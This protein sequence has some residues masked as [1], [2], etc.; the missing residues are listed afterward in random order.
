MLSANVTQQANPPLTGE[1]VGDT[2]GFRN[3]GWLGGG[4]LV[5]AVLLVAVSQPALPENG[6]LAHALDAVG[7]GLFLLY[8]GVRVWATLFIG[9]HKNSVLQTEGPYS[10]CRN[11]LY[12]GSFCFGLSVGCFLKSVTFAGVVLLVFVAYSHWVVRAEEKVLQFR[13]G[14]NY[15]DYRRRTPRFWPRFSSFHSPPHVRVDLVHLRKEVVR[16]CRAALVPVGLQII[17]EWRMAPWWP[18]FFWIP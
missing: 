17:M 18:H 5:P 4:L 1:R 16:L 14:E 6:F 9:G 8:I 11:P 3:R 7:W 10:L 12:W 13:F 15:L 2:R